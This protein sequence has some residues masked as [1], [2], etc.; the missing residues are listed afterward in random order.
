MKISLCVTTY[1][2]PEI[3]DKVLSGIRR[4]GVLP[5]E[6]IICDDGSGPETSEVIRNWQSVFPVPLRHCWQEDDGWRVAEVRNL[7]IRQSSCDYIVFLDGDC[8]PERHFIAD[9]RQLAKP[10]HA[11]MGDRSH[12]RESW[13]TR[14]NPDLATVFWFAIRNRLRKRS[15]AFRNPLETPVVHRFDSVSP[16]EL[17]HLAVGCNL[18]AW[19]KDILAVNGFNQYLTGWYLEDIELVARLLAAGIKAGKVRRRAIVYHLDHPVRPFDKEAVLE[20]T[21]EVFRRKLTSTTNGLRKGNGQ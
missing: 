12:V 7:G 6:V 20:P 1:N 19:Q 10:G 4:M 5:E 17:G 11:I 18:G 15:N 14:F 13:V 8:I 2:K 9:H 21:R 16:E 3:L